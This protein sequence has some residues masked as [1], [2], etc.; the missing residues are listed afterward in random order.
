MQVTSICTSTYHGTNN[1]WT[2]TVK[3]NEGD[4]RQ[5]DSVTIKMGA[6]SGYYAG[7][8]GYTANGSAVSVYLTGGG[9]TS[10]TVSVTKVCPA[11]EGSPANW[12]GGSPSDPRD[13]SAYTISFPDGSKPQVNNG[14]SITFTVH[15]NANSSNRKILVHSRKISTYSCSAS[16]ITPPTPPYTMSR[17][18][19][20]SRD[21]EII[22]VGVTKFHVYFNVSAG[23]EMWN[24]EVKCYT[25][26]ST[27]TVPFGNLVLHRTRDCKE[28]QNTTF[29][30][31]FEIVAGYGEMYSGMR[32]KMKAIVADVDRS[33]NPEH[34]WAAVGAPN[35]DNI[36]TGWSLYTYQ[37]PKLNS[38]SVAIGEKHANTDYTFS[39]TGTNNRAWVSY[40]SE[41]QTRYRITFDNGATWSNWT[42]AGN[43]ASWYRT[44]AQM[45]SLFPKTKDGI[46][47]KIQFKRYSPSAPDSTDTDTNHSNNK[48]WYS[49]NTK[50]YTITLKYRPRNEITCPNIMH[51]KNN[52]S[53]TSI[54]KDAFVEN[55]STLTGIYVYWN[56]NTTVANA[57]YTQGYRIRLYNSSGTVV[58]TYYTNNKY[59]TIPKSDIP[60]MQHTYIDV[61]PYFA[62]DQPHTASSAYAGNYWYYNGTITKCPFVV[63]ASKLAKPVI[64]YPV[65]NSEWINNRFRVCFQ[66]PAD[67]DKGSELE[68]YHYE[69]I[70][71]KINGTYTYRMTSNPIGKTTSGT[72]LQAANIFS[73]LASNLTYQRKIVAAPCLASNFP[74]TTTYTIQVRVKKKYTEDKINW[75]DWSNT[76]TIKVVPAVFN[77]SRGD[78]IY[79]SH[80]NNAKKTIDRVRKTYRSGLEYTSSKCSIKSNK[81]IKNTI[82]IYKLV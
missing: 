59:Y 73:A 53:G 79:A 24:T 71:L 37:E 58:H 49:D 78:I 47:A 31:A 29:N 44:A 23:N 80:Y 11:S 15:H 33:Q 6:G 42:N 25:W 18:N 62:N 77:P 57:G 40:E 10:N 52:S 21:A 22:R 7:T 12:V 16:P 1:T 14:A 67:D 74:N 36:Q 48:G 63:M 51:K 60:K 64:T 54:G 26:D 35:G 82:S 17:I 3:N 61:T 41:F 76:V 56:Y 68:T 20:S 8:C 75:S 55:N 81:D 69:D 65:N 27:G 4:K 45:R 66:L 50:E 39:F 32:Y 5:I 43:V 72:C 34:W 70:E 13:I 28:K 38:G 30:E 46:A 19:S 9:C 2:L